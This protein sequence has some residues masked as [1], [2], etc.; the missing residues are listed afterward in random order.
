[1]VGVKGMFCRAGPRVDAVIGK[2]IRWYVVATAYLF[3][4]VQLKTEVFQ[5]IRPTGISC[6]EIG[7]V[8]IMLFLI[9]Q[10]T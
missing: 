1:V 3:Y 6:V 10:Y 5:G 8:K 2:G 7:I 4:A 9:S